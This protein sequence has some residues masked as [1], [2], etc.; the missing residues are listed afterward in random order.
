MTGSSVAHVPGDELARTLFDFAG[1]VRGP[2]RLRLDRVDTQREQ[3]HHPDEED[4]RV[5]YRCLTNE[6][7][8]R[9]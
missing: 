5:G 1:P 2:G 6:R 4:R 8:S 9:D 7:G 3:R